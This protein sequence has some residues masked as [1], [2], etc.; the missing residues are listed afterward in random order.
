MIAFVLSGAGNRGPLEVGALKALQEAGLQ[1]DL[2]TATSAGAINAV[3][4]AAHGFDQP[5]LATGMQELWSQATTDVIYP[6]NLLKVAWRF[7]SKSNSL[8]SSDGVRGLIRSA[9]PAGVATFADLKIPLY[10]TSTDLLNS[11][12]YLFG[13]DKSAPLIPAVL[14]SA[15]VP[16]I[17]PPVEYNG[18]Q[19]VDGGVLANVPASVAIEKGATEIYMINA[20]YGGG[21]VKPANGVLEV[22]GHTLNTM[23]AQSLLNDLERADQDD[24]VNLYHIYLK[25]FEAISFRD[26]SKTREMVQMGY[27]QTKAFLV[28][29]VARDLE[30]ADAGHPPLTVGG[31]REYKP[32]FI[33]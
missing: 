10:T 8:Y 31:A 14:A 20:S 24:T 15:S 12:L 21:K 28:A 29:P 23:L 22:A 2:I 6:G 9:L 27:D 1:P 16:L 19:L 26:F 11:K 7:V 30:P 3:Y 32:S 5:T 13:E 33:R 17:H 4:V 18:L 25:G